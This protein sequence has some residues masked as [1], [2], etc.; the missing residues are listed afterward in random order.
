MTDIEVSYTDPYYHEPFIGE[1]PVKVQ[2][3]LIY[4]VSKHGHI[5]ECPIIYKFILN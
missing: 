4:H 3:V 2:E 1:H 5:S